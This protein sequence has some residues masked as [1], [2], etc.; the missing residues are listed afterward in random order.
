M[1]NES[2]NTHPNARV[3]HVLVKSPEGSLSPILGQQADPVLLIYPPEK[4][5]VGTVVVVVL[6]VDVLVDVVVDV[7]LVVVVG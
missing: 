7:E 4:V 1:F 5:Y 3:E 6:V 2:Y